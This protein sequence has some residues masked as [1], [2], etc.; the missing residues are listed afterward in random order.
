MTVLIGIVS[1]QGTFINTHFYFLA[2]SL[3]APLIV[4]ITHGKRLAVLCLECLAVYLGL[5]YFQ[6]APAPEVLQLPADTVKRLELLITVSCSGILFMAFYI[7]ESFSEELEIRL[8]TMASTDTLTQ[9]ANRRTFQTALVRALALAQR[10]ATPMCLAIL[11]VDFFK[12]VNDTYGHDTGDAVL[13]HVAQVMQSAARGGDLVARF[14]GEEF[15]VLMHDCVVDK[16]LVAAERIRL[17][18]QSTPCLVGVHTIAVTASI[19]IAQWHVGT[20]AKQWLEAADNALYRAK[21]AGRNR[22]ELAALAS[23]AA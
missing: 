15:V 1:G 2:F 6:W 18:L 9:L 10:N 11:D 17:A 5:E 19:G 13:Q 23:S 16:A 7:S 12:R 8:R 3:T 20:E 4:P 22:V 21:Q 14:G